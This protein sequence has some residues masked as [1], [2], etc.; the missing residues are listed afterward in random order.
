MKL[1]ILT[2]LLTSLAAFSHECKDNTD[3]K[4]NDEVKIINVTEYY[5]NI[6]LNQTGVISRKYASNYSC[7]TA[8]GV[9]YTV[10]IKLKNGDYTSIDVCANHL[11]KVV[12]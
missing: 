11:K 1:L 9:Q 2:I 10:S 5:E 3:F 6:F 4:L 8:D 7:K 12:K